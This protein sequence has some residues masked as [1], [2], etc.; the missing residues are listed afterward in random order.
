MT[1]TILLCSHNSN[2]SMISTNGEMHTH[3]CNEDKQLTPGSQAKQTLEELSNELLISILFQISDK[4][5]LRSLV[6]ASPACHAVYL[7]VRRKVLNC[8]LE[9]QYSQFL[10]DLSEAIAVIRSKGLYMEADR[11]KAIAFLDSWRRRDEIREPNLTPT[12]QLYEPSSLE[13]IIELF[14]FY[15]EMEFFIDDYS[16]NVPRPTWMNADKWHNEVLPL[17]L[18]AT[19]K[20][21]I[22]RVPC[23][24][25]RPA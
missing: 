16:K 4:N 18:S 6:L 14:R 3:S 17:T 5:S 24:Q 22:F 1:T 7:T 10:P 15:H 20:L 8:I 19:E 23:R 12:T 13:E 25:V 21:R 9:R 11:E 2:P